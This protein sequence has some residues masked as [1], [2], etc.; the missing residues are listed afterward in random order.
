MKKSIKL[1]ISTLCLTAFLISVS[2]V[3]ASAYPGPCHSPKPC[4]IQS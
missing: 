2:T 1:I 3:S 4:V